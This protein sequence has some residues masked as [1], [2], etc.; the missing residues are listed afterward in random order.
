[1]GLLTPPGRLSL[2]VR[3]GEQC[4]AIGRA[5]VGIRPDFVT[6][7][8]GLTVPYNF[9]LSLLGPNRIDDIRGLYVEN[10]HADA[11]GNGGIVFVSVPQTGQLIQVPWQASV[12][13]PLWIAPSGTIVFT[14]SPNAGAGQSGGAPLVL[15][16]NF[17]PKPSVRTGLTV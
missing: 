4:L 10:F 13:L 5:V 17:E 8:G 12:L 9:D 2:P 1:V 3:L 14:C 6:L 16:L 11:N 7:V 15:L